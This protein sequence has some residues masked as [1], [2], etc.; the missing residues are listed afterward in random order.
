MAVKDMHSKGTHSLIGAGAIV[1]GVVLGIG[2]VY[3]DGVNDAQIAVQA[4]AVNADCLGNYDPKLQHTQTNPETK[5]QGLLGKFCKEPN[6]AGGICNG[7]CQAPGKCLATGCDGKGLEGKPKEMPKEMGG[8]PPMLPMPPMG[9]PK[10]D[11][12][13]EPEDPCK[14]DASSTE[15][16]LKRGTNGIGNYLS[17]LF[18]NS[19]SSSTPGT[20]KTAVQSVA[21][22][23][24]AF[25]SGDSESESDTNTNTS[26]QNPTSAFVTPIVTGANVRQITAQSGTQGNAN[27]GSTGGPTNVAV[28]GFGSGGA[29]VDTSTGP[30]LAAM[31]N[32]TTRIQAILS[33]LF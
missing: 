30:I 8:M 9:M 4:Q 31:K 24:S 25:L 7:T 20:I 26:T 28:T 21:S 27:T 12:P 3:W 10:P 29:S 6:G 1:L 2:V 14:T 22:K 19:N 23:L 5:Q 32:I 17:N 15:C 13:K 16:Q 11:M 33:S 18:G